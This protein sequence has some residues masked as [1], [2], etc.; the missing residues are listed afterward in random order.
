MRALKAFAKFWYDFVVGDDWKTAVLVLLPLAAAALLLRLGDPADP[1]LAVVGGILVL[2]GFS[3]S[4]A[5]EARRG[6][7]GG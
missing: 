3:L 4:M 6:R 2:A 1:V 7:A 5:L